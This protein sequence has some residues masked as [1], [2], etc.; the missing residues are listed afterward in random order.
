MVPGPHLPAAQPDWLLQ[1]RRK[2]VE[3]QDRASD[4]E[5]RVGDVRPEVQ[6]VVAGEGL[7]LLY[8]S[9]CVGRCTEGGGG[10]GRQGL[11]VV[12]KSGRTQAA[13]CAAGLEAAGASARRLAAA[14]CVVTTRALREYLAKDRPGS[15]LV[16]RRQPSC[17]SHCNSCNSRKSSTHRLT[18]M[19]SGL[20]PA[21][22]RVG[23]FPAAALAVRAQCRSHA[24]DSMRRMTR[25]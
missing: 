3:R 24:N 1:L 8:A 12:S 17:N 20:A 4:V 23:S 7:V 15:P 21:T 9:L 2:A 18:F 22:P 25:L 14:V 5:R 19:S 16:T 13:H 11:R 10:G 6:Q